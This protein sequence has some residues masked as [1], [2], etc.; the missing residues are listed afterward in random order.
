MSQQKRNKIS[1]TVTIEQTDSDYLQSEALRR[2]EIGGKI[3]SISHVLREIIQEHEKL[4][5]ILI[6]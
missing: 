2:S 6:E 4:F 1:L 5:R 3:L